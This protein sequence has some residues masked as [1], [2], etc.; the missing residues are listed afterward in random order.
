MQN[1][2]PPLPRC[3]GSRGSLWRTDARFPS[4]PAICRWIEAPGA[5][6]ARV[7]ARVDRTCRGTKDAS[8]LKKNKTAKQPAALVPSVPLILASASAKARVCKNNHDRSNSED[9]ARLKHAAGCYPHE[10]PST[11]T[12][13]TPRPF[14]GGRPVRGGCL[15]GATSCRHFF[16]KFCTRSR[17]SLEFVSRTLGTWYEYE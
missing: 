11:P 6:L 12:R 1:L 15:S 13:G 8:H 9:R 16:L 10:D 14:I 4:A 17:D 5:L 3:D 7:L 2:E